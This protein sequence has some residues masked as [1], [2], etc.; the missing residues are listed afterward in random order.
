MRQPH[1]FLRSFI[2]SRNGLRTAWRDDASFRRSVWQVVAG[3]ILATVLSLWLDMSEGRWLLLVASLLPIIVIELLNTAIEA[4]TDKASPERHPLARKAKDIG[5]AAVLITR[6]M[7]ALVW[8][9][10]I[11]DTLF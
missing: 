3:V 5:S 9:T 2:N 7:T 11:F 8:I 6:L 10:V 1:P 4:V